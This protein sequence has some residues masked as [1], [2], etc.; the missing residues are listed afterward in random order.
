MIK[1]LLLVCEQCGVTP[2]PQL[3]HIIRIRK[4][5][6]GRKGGK[7]GGRYGGRS[8]AKAAAT[9]RRL[10]DGELRGMMILEEDLDEDDDEVDGGA[11]GLGASDFES[12]QRPRSIERS[13]SDSSLG[14]SFS[15]YSAISKAVTIV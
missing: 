15:D 11:R 8:K 4:T 7:G 9:R 10:P 14:S 5:R 2:P 1:S 6:G 3:L 12:S 13:D